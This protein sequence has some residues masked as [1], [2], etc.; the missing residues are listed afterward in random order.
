MRDFF[1]DFLRII[2]KL[3]DDALLTVEFLHLTPVCI[4]YS[5][6]GINI[7]SYALTYVI[8]KRFRILCVL[9]QQVLH[10]SFNHIGLQERRF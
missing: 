8:L 2:Y 3:F 6:R 9:F 5:T 10:Y 1:I 7:L 4:V